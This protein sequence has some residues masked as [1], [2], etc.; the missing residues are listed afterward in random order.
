M[1]CVTFPPGLGVKVP[2]C[3]VRLS[4]EAL[5]A[6]SSFSS[7]RPCAP[8]AELGSGLLSS[9]SHLSVAGGRS[10]EGGGWA[11]F[12]PFFPF[13]DCDCLGSMGRDRILV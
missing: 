1:V 11:E 10:G 8:P 4:L 5:W 9:R 6:P 2:S 13:L 3:Q 7:A 12:F